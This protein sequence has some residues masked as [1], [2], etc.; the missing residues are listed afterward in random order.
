MAAASSRSCAERR[1][2]PDD[3]ETGAEALLGMGRAPG[4]GRRAPRPMA[5][6]P[7]RIAPD[8]L[9]GPVGVA[10]MAGRHVLRHGRVLAVAAAAHW[11]AIRSPLANISTVRGGEADLDLGADEAVGH[12]VEMPSTST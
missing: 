12:A 9:D 8:A 7:C 4:S 11:A 3:A 2:Q 5:R 10:P 6:S 1:D